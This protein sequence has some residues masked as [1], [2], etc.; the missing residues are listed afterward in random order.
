MGTFVKSKRHPMKPSSDL[1]HRIQ[2][3]KDSRTSWF[4][5]SRS[6]A[7]SSTRSQ[8]QPEVYRKSQQ[9]SLKPGSNGL[10]CKHKPLKV[11]PALC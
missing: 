11:V 2:S 7:P 9:A 5:W 3:V 6:A 10:G 1:S 8:Y 4:V